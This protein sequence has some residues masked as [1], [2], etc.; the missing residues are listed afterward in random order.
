MNRSITFGNLNVRINC[1]YT[2]QKTNDDMAAQDWTVENLQRNKE[3]RS[4]STKSPNA[5]IAETN[6]QQRSRML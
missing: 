1:D 3:K 4:N 6:M 5:D 2:S